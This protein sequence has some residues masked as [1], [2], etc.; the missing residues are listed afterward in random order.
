MELIVSHITQP[1]LDPMW[2]AFLPWATGAESML[3]HHEVPTLN[4]A[5]CPLQGARLEQKMKAKESTHSAWQDCWAVWSGY[6]PRHP[7]GQLPLKAQGL[8]PGSDRNS[9]AFGEDVGFLVQRKAEVSLVLTHTPIFI[10]Y[11]TQLK[12]KSNEE[13]GPSHMQG[14]PFPF[15]PSTRTCRL[16]QSVLIIKVCQT[17]VR[18]GISWGHSTSLSKVSCHS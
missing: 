4:P 7:S 11:K 2:P 8:V 15:P 6:D 9:L 3:H 13:Q 1:T 18:S 14:T 12:S 5:S 16:V 10:I 17:E